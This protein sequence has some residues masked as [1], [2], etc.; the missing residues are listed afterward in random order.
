[1]LK[2]KKEPRSLAIVS[3]L[4]P[5][6]LGKLPPHMRHNSPP[7]Y[8]KV[9]EEK[10]TTLGH[11]SYEVDEKNRKLILKNFNLEI[12][13]SA[14]VVRKTKKVKDYDHKK[15]AQYASIPVEVGVEETKTGK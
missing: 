7:S 4:K 9:R 13:F 12:E 5:K 11:D 1:M 8:W 14:K 6:K 2:H 15:N 10:K 3:L